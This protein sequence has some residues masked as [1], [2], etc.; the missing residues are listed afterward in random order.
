MLPFVQTTMTTQDKHTAWKNLLNRHNLADNPTS[1]AYD[2]LFPWQFA[3]FNW[4]KDYD[5]FQSVQK[6]RK[7]GFNSMKL[8]TAEMYIEWLKELDRLGV[9]PPIGAEKAGGSSSSRKG[10]AEAPAGGP[11]PAAVA[12]EW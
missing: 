12:K 3:D 9:M 7:A 6:L 2:K 11:G 4:T 1:A 10:A 8:D 5:F